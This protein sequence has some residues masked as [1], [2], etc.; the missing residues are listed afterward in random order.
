[1]ERILITLFVR[2]VMVEEDWVGGGSWAET[3]YCSLRMS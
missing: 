2:G 1:V 3:M